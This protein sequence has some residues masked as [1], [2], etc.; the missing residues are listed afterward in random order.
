MPRGGWR[1]LTSTA[2]VCCYCWHCKGLF[3]HVIEVP[4]RPV[5][6]ALLSRVHELRRGQAAEQVVAL[7][8]RHGLLDEQ[9]MLTLDPRHTHW[10][11]IVRDSSIPGACGVCKCDGGGGGF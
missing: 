7:L 8:T 6:P 4:P 9:G 11:R 3:T 2:A 1:T 5:T 10:P